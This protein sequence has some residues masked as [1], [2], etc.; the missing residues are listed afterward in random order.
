MREVRLFIATSEDGFIADETGSIEWL[1]SLV[2]S[3]GEDGGF[4]SMYAQIDTIIMGRKTFEH[5]V[6]LCDG[7]F[8]HQDRKTMLVTAQADYPILPD[9]HGDQISI[10]SRDLVEHVRAL[11]EEKGDAVWLCGGASVIN[12]LMR[13]KLI[14]EVVITVIPV[15][16]AR[17]VALWDTTSKQLFHDWEIQTVRDFDN[18]KQSTYKRRE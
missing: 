14:D 17:G 16:L 11:K 13:A 12:Q 6:H 18:C 10:W 15:Q 1:T 9:V 7:H 2:F 5:V 3:E 8:P 4:T